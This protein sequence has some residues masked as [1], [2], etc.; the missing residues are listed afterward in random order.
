MALVCG[1]GGFIG[2]HMVKRLKGEGYW[3]RGAD[4]KKPEF[5]T[6]MADEFLVGDLCDDAF[7]RKVLDRPFDETY[8][9]AAD[10]GGAGFV[11]TGDHDADIMRNSAAI[12]LNILHV[13]QAT[14]NVKKIFYSSSACIYPAY[15]QEDP[16][17]P[18]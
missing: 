4:I 10:M 15:N 17:N 14:G 6:S 18:K 13:G 11:F 16:N 8:Q 3:V 9:F 12:S 5:G 7:V 1:A 2:S